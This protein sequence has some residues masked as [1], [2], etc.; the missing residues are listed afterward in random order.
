MINKLNTIRTGI[1]VDLHS[2]ENDIVEDCLIDNNEKTSHNSQKNFI[3]LGGVQIECKY[4]VKAH[5]DGDVLLHAIADAIYGGSCSGN[6]GVY[7]SPNDPQWAN[8]DSKIFI[9]HA[10]NKAAEL[11]WSIEYIDSSIICE[12]PK[13][14]PYSKQISENISK[15]LKLNPSC[16]SVKATTPEGLPFLGVQHGIVAF[17]ICTLNCMQDK[18]I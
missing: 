16:I 8:C 12:E 2:F 17:V 6:I 14:M 9:Q 18:C 11:G 4:K 10:K 7:F 13:I 3:V 1:G 15:I 5:S